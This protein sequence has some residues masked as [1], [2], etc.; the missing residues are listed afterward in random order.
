MFCGI[1]EEART[2]RR[3]GGG[4]RVLMEKD[5]QWP[6]RAEEAGG[7]GRKKAHSKLRGNEAERPAGREKGTRGGQ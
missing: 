2:Q 6:Q 3:M 5:Q 1:E 7:T 4:G